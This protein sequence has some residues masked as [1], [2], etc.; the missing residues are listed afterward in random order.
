MKL[1]REQFLQ[2][3]KD[4]TIE[5]CVDDSSSGLHRHVVFSAGGCSIMRFHL[6]TIPGYLFFTGDMGTF[7]FQRLPDMFNF[8]RPKDGKWRDDLNYW[9][10]KLEAVDKTD[11]AL[12]NSKELFAE[13]LY[14]YI[15]PD[16]DQ[17]V[18]GKIEDGIEEILGEYDDFGFD[19][20]YEKALNFSLV[21]SGTQLPYFTFYDLWEHNFK[22][23]TLR[24]QWACMAIQWGIEQYDAMK[25]KVM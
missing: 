12:E 17:K 11:G 21:H 8:F 1:T 25:V 15:E 6:A 23:P 18:K 9:Y 4:H 24:F 22:V 20:A 14:G 5:S 13:T 19:R 2:D 16:M 7:V 10:Q 3:V